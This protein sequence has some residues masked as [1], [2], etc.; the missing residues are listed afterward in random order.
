MKRKF[1]YLTYLVILIIISLPLSMVQGHNNPEVTMNQE[2]LLDCPPIQNTPSFTI[3]YG[4]VSLNQESAPVGSVIKT[5][6]PRG[7]L[8]GCFKTTSIGN[9]GMMFVY[10]ED[11]TINP[12]IPGMRAGET[13]TFTINDM[14]ATSNPVL[15]WQNDRDIHNVNLESQGVTADFSATP[16]SGVLPLNVTFSDLSVGEIDN[17]LWDF[18]D[19]QTSTLQ[20]P[21]HPYL[22]PGMYTVSLTV[23]GATGSDTKTKNSYIKVYTPVV[24][25]FSSDI[26][27]GIAPLTVN[28]LN[29]STGD[30]SSSSWNF[31]DSGTSTLKNPSH[32]YFVG[33]TYNVSLTVSGNGGTDTEIKNAYITVYNKVTAGFTVD[34]NNGVYPLTVNFTNTSTGDYTNLSWDFGDGYTS[35]MEN[36]S[37]TFQGKG[38]YIVTLTASG[39]GGTHQFSDTINV[40]QQ[41]EAGFTGSPLQGLSPLTVNFTNESVGDYTSV[42]WN[43]GDGETSTLNNPSHFYTV[44]GIYTVSLTISGPGGEDTITKT[45]YVNV[46]EPSQALF[47]ATPTEGVTPLAVNFSNLSTGSF[48]TQTWD[49]GDGFNSNEFE[50]IHTY[51]SSGIYTVTLTVNG[52]GGQ[53]TE[54]KNNYI[55]VHTPVSA[56]FSATPL[57]GIAPL[58]IAFTNLSTGTYDTLTWDFGDSATSDIENPTHT[59]SEPGTYTVSLTVSGLGGTDTE[60]KTGYITVYAPVTADFSATPLSGIAP[61]EVSFTNLSTGTYDTLTWDFGDSATSDVENPTH[62]YSETGTYTVSLT[63]SGFGGTDTETK[64]GYITVYAPV[65]ADFSATPLS[66][67]APLEIAFTNLSTGTYDTLTWNFGDGGTSNLENPA[68][69]YSEPGTYTVSLTVSGLG[70]TDTE[71]KT[72]YITVYAPVTADFS[73]TPLSGIAPLEIAFTNLS[74]GTYDTY[75]WDFGD[76]ET[77]ALENPAHT[78]SE[79]GTYTVSLTVS[80]LGGTDTETKTGYIS[81]G[82][83]VAAEFTGTPTSGIAPISISFENLSTGDFDTFTWDFGDGNTSAIENP[84]HTYSEPGIYTVSLT[85]TGLGGTDTETK[86]NYI[87]VFEPVKALFSATPTTGTPPLVVQFTNQSTGS[88]DEVEWDFGDGS[89]SREENPLHAFIEPGSYTVRL[90]VSGPGGSDSYEL[91]ITVSPHKIYLPI[92]LNR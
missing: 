39:P 85:I 87:I 84:T 61:L 79:P 91:I 64:T 16:L 1:T 80:G 48:D 43:F 7:E 53:A 18:G 73:A 14:P 65:T 9:Y 30:Y 23:S 15:L 58:E 92:I 27:T 21:S 54:I 36:P 31:G 25:D 89:T 3:V 37:H 86:E 17:W 56:D 69:T 76:G 67:I 28:F 90:A 88:Y 68:H 42:L 59:Y 52:P 66:G 20:N 45:S 40:Y 38:S 33:G 57:S 29:S 77:S 83:Q 10:G 12:P 32:T 24:S 75:T 51:T 81:V 19:G 72:G 74:T 26:T 13:V 47:Y 22:N 49:F 34:R 4:N 46:F 63:V 82:L 8:V 62:I 6:N 2:I 78:Y 71:T 70:G 5:F 44:S 11:N 55:T 35:G 41:V 50:P 60:T